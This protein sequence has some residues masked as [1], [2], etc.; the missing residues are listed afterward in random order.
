MV[1]VF[2]VEAAHALD[3]R[4][5]GVD[6]EHDALVDGERGRAAP[7]AA[8]LHGLQPVGA[9]VEG[10]A[11]QRGPVLLHPLP[12][13]RAVRDVARR[14]AHVVLHL[15]AA[16]RG[17]L[18]LRPALRAARQAVVLVPCPAEDVRGADGRGA[19]ADVLGRPDK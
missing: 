2:G 4:A 12:D 19:S 18:A 9:H 6:A 11:R 13:G 3:A 16:R 10:G 7:V 1:I 15:V 5:V 8:L 14:H 17:R